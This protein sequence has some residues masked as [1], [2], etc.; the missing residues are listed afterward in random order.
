[1]YLKQYEN[2]DNIYYAKSRDGVVGW[3]YPILSTFLLKCRMWTSS[4]LFLTWRR[5]AFDTVDRDTLWGVQEKFWCPLSM[6]QIIKEVYTDNLGRIMLGEGPSSP[7]RT[8]CGVFTALTNAVLY[9]V[10]AQSRSRNVCISY[11]S[12]GDVLDLRCLKVKSKCRKKYILELQCTDDCAFIASIRQQLQDT[13]KCFHNAYTALG[14]K[15]NT[16]KTRQKSLQSWK[17]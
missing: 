13:I 15:L 16:S 4:S 3:Y 5:H 11:K 1:M 14:L 12:K 7:F 17:P 10:D 9:L 6:L 2:Y 8:Q